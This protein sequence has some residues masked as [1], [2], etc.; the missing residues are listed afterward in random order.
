MNVNVEDVDGVK[1]LHLEGDLSGTGRNILVEV[2]TDLLA[3]PQARLIIDLGQV[4]YM[5]SAGL[6]DLVRLVAQANVQEARVVLANLS[7]YISGVIEMTKL[8]RFFEIHP[9]IEDALRQMD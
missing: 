2:V 3:A 1:I 4:H 6:G 9:T 5:N 7:A 8:N